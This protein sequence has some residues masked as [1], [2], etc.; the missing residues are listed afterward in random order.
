V[1]S[2]LAAD[3]LKEPALVITE[4]FNVII[5]LEGQLELNLQESQ[6]SQAEF[7]RLCKQ[8]GEVVSGRAEGCQGCQGAG[9]NNLIGQLR[10]QLKREFANGE[11]VDSIKKKKERSRARFDMARLVEAEEV[12]RRQL[13]YQ[14]LKPKE[15]PRATEQARRL[16]ELLKSSV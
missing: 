4:L 3:K 13:A 12:I 1:V 14:D 5:P 8:L 7:T 11:A 9:K 10:K 16:R 6:G 15:K 2:A